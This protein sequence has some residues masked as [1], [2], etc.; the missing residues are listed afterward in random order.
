MDSKNEGRQ[1]PP[2]LA[3]LFTCTARTRGLPGGRV[4]S[5]SF[6]SPF[7]PAKTV[8]ATRRG[9]PPKDMKLVGSGGGLSSNGTIAAEGGANGRRGCASSGW[10]GRVSVSPSRFRDLGSLEPPSAHAG[11]PA[12]PS[13]QSGAGGDRPRRRPHRSRALNDICGKNAAGAGPA[14]VPP[15]N[16]KG[17]APPPGGTRPRSSSQTGGG[18]STDQRRRRRRRVPRPES[19]GRGHATRRPRR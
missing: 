13:A 9:G 14:C 4:R 8:M 5:R 15:T 11:R 7:P 6:P 1:P 17:R 2:W 19:A 3:A 10:G 16:E 12:Q 18:R